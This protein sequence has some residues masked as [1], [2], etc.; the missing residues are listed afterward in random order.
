M[1]DNK[2]SLLNHIDTSASCPVKDG[3]QDSQNEITFSSAV[4]LMPEARQIEIDSFGPSERAQAEEIAMIIAEIYRLPYEC[5]IRIDGIDMPAPMVANAFRMLT[6]DHVA[7]VIEQFRKVTARITHT[8]TYLRTSLYNS[9]F[10]LAS[11]IEN[12]VRHDLNG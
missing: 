4:R 8:K 10:E 11:S 1:K 3:E 2:L 9:V 6:H 12:E 7:H 5:T